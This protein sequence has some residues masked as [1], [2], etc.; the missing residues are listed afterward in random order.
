MIYLD[1][2]KKIEPILT[3]ILTM[4]ESEKELITGI[5]EET[6]KLYKGKNKFFNH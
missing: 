2:T 4:T 6:I 5:R 1:L 3:K